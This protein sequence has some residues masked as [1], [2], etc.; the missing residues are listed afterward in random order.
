MEQVQL[1][2]INFLFVEYFSCIHTY[3]LIIFF[4]C[5]V[6]SFYGSAGLQ[7]GVPLRFVR[8]VFCVH[9]HYVDACVENAVGKHLKDRLFSD[10]K[11]M[12]DNYVFTKLLLSKLLNFLR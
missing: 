6:T 1:K 11:N 3:L 2:K 12:Q 10:L 7:E 5:L 4:R 9:A 8:Q